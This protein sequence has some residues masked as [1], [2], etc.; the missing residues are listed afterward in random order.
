MPEDRPDL[1]VVSPDTHDDHDHAPDD[2]THLGLAADT[3]MMSRTPVDRRR[4]LGLGALGVGTLLGAA[5]LGSRASAALLGGGGAPPVGA[6]PGGAPPGGAPAGQ[7]DADTVSSA[8]GQCTT[9]PE[10]TNGPYP[11]DG[12]GASGQT[13]MILNKSGIVRR[14]LTRSL[15]TGHRVSG[16]PLKLTM[17]LVDVDNNCAPLAGHVIYVWQCTASG[18]YSLYS[19]GVT[20]E[21]YLRGVQV[22]DAQGRVTFETIFPGCYPGRW[23]HIHFEVYPNLGAAVAGNV[24]K[25][26]SLVSQ[27]AL[28]EKESRLVYADRRYGNSTRNLNQL[29]LAT[30]TVFSDG[31][32]AQT[33]RVTGSVKAGYAAS[34]NVG[35][36]S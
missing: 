30:D 14:D 8:D 13:V 32:K 25:N 29:T 34:I 20:A 6:P 24:D 22:S 12:S 16:V 7:G 17:Q 21:D 10:E 33:P 35:L 28:P 1:L 19:Q 15:G 5:A 3:N 31:A 36:K 27:I 23:P 11:A 26:V 2:F 9:L 18:E 4:L